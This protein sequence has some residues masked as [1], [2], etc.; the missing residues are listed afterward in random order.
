MIKLMKALLASKEYK[1]G[2][3]CWKTDTEKTQREKESQSLH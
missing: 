1:D 2:V 3:A